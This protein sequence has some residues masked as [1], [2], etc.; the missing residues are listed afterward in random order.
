MKAMTFSEFQGRCKDTLDAVIDDC[1]E[2]VVMRPQHE[3]VVI[4][5]LAEY[6]SLK[7][8][9]FLL[10][11]SANVYRLIESIERLESGQGLRRELAE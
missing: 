9:A 1:E 6:E 2:V 10:R 5:S 8:T 11:S 7:E 3:P 4:L